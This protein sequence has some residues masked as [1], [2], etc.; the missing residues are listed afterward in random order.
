MI[1]LNLVSNVVWDL[2]CVYD[3]LHKTISKE[4]ANNFSAYI[5]SNIFNWLLLSN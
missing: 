4:V 3:K 5:L 1:Y 2:N